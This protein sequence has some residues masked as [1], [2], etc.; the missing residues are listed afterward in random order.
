MSLAAILVVLSSLAAQAADI[1]VYAPN[2]VAGPL[3]I[4][5]A[6]WTAATGNKVA[7]AGFNVGR[8]RAAVEKDDP[9]DVV[10]APTGNFAEFVPKLKTGSERVLGR[11]P[12][13]VVVKAG[14]AHPD[15]SSHEKFVAFTKKAWCWPMP[16]PR[17]AA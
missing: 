6:E 12:F 17:W 7:F 8:V 3:K 5:A 16:I 9:G 14:G 11:I 4:L 10:V 15:I 2:I 13:G 1:T